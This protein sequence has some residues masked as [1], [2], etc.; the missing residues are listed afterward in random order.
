[1]I[2]LGNESILPASVSIYGREM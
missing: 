2:A 1:M